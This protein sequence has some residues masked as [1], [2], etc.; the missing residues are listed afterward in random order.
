MIFE[1]GNLEAGSVPYIP[2][3]NDN[4]PAYGPK[5][6]GLKSSFL[7]GGAEKLNLPILP[8]WWHEYLFQFVAGA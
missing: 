3:S 7:D 6:I 8:P 1:A 5:E 2:T 4:S